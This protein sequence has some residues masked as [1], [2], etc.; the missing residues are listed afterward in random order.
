MTNAEINILVDSF[1]EYYR[2]RGKEK[3]LSE[4]HKDALAFCIFLMDNGWGLYTSTNKAGR[5]YRVSVKLLRN[6]IKKNVTSI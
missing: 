5:H 4:T 2:F 6:I 3:T 1:P